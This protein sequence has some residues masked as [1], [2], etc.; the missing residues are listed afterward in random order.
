[1]NFETREEAEVWVIENQI[2]R[3]NLNPMQLSYFRGLHYRADKKSHGDISRTAL[4]NASVQNAHLQTGS[5]AK[6]LA[7]KYNVMASFPEVQKLS[8]IINSFAR[9]ISSLVQDMKAGNPAELKSTIRSY[10]DELE[11]LYQ[12]I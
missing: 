6:K 9:D 5:T 2:S 10:I 12:N 3:R 11:E 1:M 4:N 7:E 8:S